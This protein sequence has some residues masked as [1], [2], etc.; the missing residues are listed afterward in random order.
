MSALSIDQ[1]RAKMNS[2]ASG[3]P[4]PVTKLEESTSSASMDALRNSLMSKVLPKESVQPIEESSSP[5]SSGD[6]LLEVLGRK[7]DTLRE[8]TQKMDEIRS[9]V[10]SPRLDVIKGMI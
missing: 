5:K 9:R 3:A 10:P 8:D 7:A 4:V 1:M 6:L 2:V